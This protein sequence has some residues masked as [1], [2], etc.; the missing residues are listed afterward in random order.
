[1]RPVGGAGRH[2]SE[3]DQTVH[4]LGAMSRAQALE[5]LRDHV[6]ARLCVRYRVDAGGQ[7]RFADSPDSR[8]RPRWPSLAAL[9]LTGLFGCTAPQLGLPGT[10][11]ADAPIEVW[12]EPVAVP[13]VVESSPPPLAEPCEGN[14]SC[15]PAVA[16]RRDFSAIVELA[17]SANGDE[18]RLMLGMSGSWEPED[19]PELSAREQRR[20]RRRVRR[21]R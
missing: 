21:A 7:L 18:P 9:G 3:C 4:D 10:G 2:C 16:D 20:E 19:E 1:M 17:P 15:D 11:T 5:L 13:E 12:P 6:G 14:G 8:P